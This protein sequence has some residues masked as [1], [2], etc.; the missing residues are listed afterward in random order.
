[1]GL[2]KGKKMLLKY[3]YD[4]A[5]DGGAVST[6]ALS[7]V[8]GN[9]LLAG[10]KVVGM[11]VVVETAI[12]SGGSPTLTIGNTTDADGYAADCVALLDKGFQAG[13]VAGDLIY[14][15]TNDHL[16]MYSP[17]VADDLDMNIVIG[18]AALTAG[19]F[20]IYLE[21]LA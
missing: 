5:V 14:D 9:E 16:I 11:Y 6:I 15:D 8:A 7:Q 17:L 3:D 1:M 19:K 18:T 21:I 13:E 2:L 10:Y 20:A 4:F 12:T